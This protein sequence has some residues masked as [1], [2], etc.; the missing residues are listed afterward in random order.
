MENTQIEKQ[1]ATIHL[2]ILRNQKMITAFINTLPP[3]QR[4]QFI[5][6]YNRLNIQ[7]PVALYLPI[8]K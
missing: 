4:Q 6:E 2:E 3:E 1:L 5:Q 8:K 7:N